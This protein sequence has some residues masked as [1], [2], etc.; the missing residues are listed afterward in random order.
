MPALRAAVRLGEALRGCWA[1]RGWGVPP[2]SQHPP[3]S[4]S[5]AMGTS[6]STSN[7]STALTGGRRQPP[8]HGLQPSPPRRPSSSTVMTRRWPH[9]TVSGTPGWTRA[10][11][12]CPSALPRAGV[13]PGHVVLPCNLSDLPPP[14]CPAAF[15]S[16]HGVLGPE[17]LQQ[18]LGQEHIFVAQEQTVSNQVRA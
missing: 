18:A 8:L 4:A 12:H 9:Y 13:E 11:S 7:G 10:W 14:L 16:S 2:L 15:Q 6:S 17:R 3:P 5:T 1:C